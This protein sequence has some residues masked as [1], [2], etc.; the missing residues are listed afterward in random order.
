LEI[1]G[2]GGELRARLA[3]DVDQVADIASDVNPC[4]P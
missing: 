3:E 4:R 1:A 2:E